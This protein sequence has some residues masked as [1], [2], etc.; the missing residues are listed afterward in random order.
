MKF[1]EYFISRRPIFS[2]AKD[3]SM[4]D[5]IETLLNNQAILEAIYIASPDFYD[6]IEKYKNGSLKTKK[7]LDDFFYSFN[8]Y[9]LRMSTNPVPFGLFSSIGVHNYDQSYQTDDMWRFFDLD[10]TVFLQICEILHSYDEILPT[11]ILGRNSSWNQIDDTK[12]KYSE[13]R[14][15]NN[16]FEIELA[17][18]EK[19]DFL[20]ELI[21]RLN[22]GNKISIDQGIQIGSSLEYS[23][24][25]VKTYIAQLVRNN[26]LT[27][28]LTPN[29]IEFEPKYTVLSKITKPL[30]GSNLEDHN[31]QTI[32][33]ICDLIESCNRSK[34]NSLPELI[35]ITDL[36]KN[37][38]IE[39]SSIKSPLLV[40]TYNTKELS[41]NK[42]TILESVAGSIELL[43][44]LFDSS[45]IHDSKM[46]EFEERFHER[47]FDDCVKLEDALD[48]VFGIGYPVNENRRVINPMVNGMP[49]NFKTAESNSKSSIDDFQFRLL[50]TVLQN[51]KN[52]EIKLDLVEG[53]DLYLSEK[54]LKY[55]AANACI[56][57][58]VETEGEK[59][60]YTLNHACFGSNTRL[61]GRFSSGS[62]DIE[63]IIVE[64]NKESIAFDEDRILADFSFFQKPVH[65]NIGTAKSGLTHAI[66]HLNRGYEQQTNLYPQD[67]Y[68]RIINSKL[69]LFDIKSGKMVD[70]FV[71]NATNPTKTLDPIARFLSDYQFY[72]RIPAVR[73]SLPSII[74]SLPF[75]PRITF[76][77]FILSPARW[78]ITK[79]ELETL[80]KKHSLTTH[81]LL[82][83]HMTSMKVE[84]SVYLE[85]EEERYRIEPY[86]DFGIRFILNKLN[87]NGKVI[88]QESRISL[89][90]NI[91]QILLFG[92]REPL[93]KTQINLAN[94]K[95]YFATVIQDILSISI[96]VKEKN[97]DKTLLAITDKIMAEFPQ[98]KFFIV[99]YFDPL[100][101]FRLR[102]VDWQNS[103]NINLILTILN[104]F[105]TE[106]IISSYKLEPFKP[107]LNRYG[108]DE[109]IRLSYE[110]FCDETSFI[111]NEL[112]LTNEVNL[113][114]VFKRILSYLH[115][116]AK[117][118]DVL[119]LLEDGKNGFVNE[120]Q[121]TSKEGKKFLEK[122]FREHLSILESIENENFEEKDVHTTLNTYLKSIDDNIEY[123]MSS[124][125]HMFI[126]RSV[127]SSQ[128]Q[129]ETVVY[130]SL[131]R[132][133]KMKF[134][135]KK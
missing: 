11:F 9:L 50:K 13:K 56:M 82:K 10:G 108:G 67:L 124:L 3:F 26:F 39:V 54:Q 134:H 106:K 128:R 21:L 71:G 1:K 104:N 45:L 133:Y 132:F 95:V 20:D 5:T 130:Y 41:C 91:S 57:L 4:G 72:K 103:V 51:N 42:N 83:Q 46:S 35:R 66:V 22:K 23:E 6:A 78:L 120:F 110:I 59:E 87:R 114:S 80:A 81:E 62:K 8:N 68:L 19:N 84:E 25:D 64:L 53:I 97:S 60:Y 17:S 129:V 69:A 121:L 63:N 73:F 90:G 131:W 36:V 74:A 98:C 49:V 99:R 107:E 94:K 2:Y 31:I 79:K 118:A 32:A 113:I 105:Q 92:N 15:K 44:S 100:F 88:L 33:E 37:L 34:N 28:Q 89:S 135:L 52:E 96:Y 61:I 24:I 125:I 65:L 27:T 86:K 58:D 7:E 48:P 14:L 40:N 47:Y 117:Y 101:H 18:I 30:L 85:E 112:K 119:Q 12:I 29:S 77:G 102:F 16:L 109:L 123:T 116:Y 38:G 111:L 70:V 126:N 122:K 127:N 55:E 115:I 75:V 43:L 76:K 93:K